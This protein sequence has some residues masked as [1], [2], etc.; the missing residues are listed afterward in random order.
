[1]TDPADVESARAHRRLLDRLL[2]DAVPAVGTFRQLLPLMAGAGPVD[3]LQGLVRLRAVEGI[4]TRA[5]QLIRDASATPSG[6]S[7]VDQPAALPLPHPLDSEWRFCADSVD[8]LVSKLLST[9]MPGD[10]L[11]LVGTPSLAVALSRSCADRRIRFVGPD[12]VVS[13][14]VADLFEGDGRLARKSSG[15]AAAA[16]VDP[17][18]YGAP[19]AEM[20]SVCAS[21]CRPGAPVLTVMPRLATRPDMAAGIEDM[22]RAAHGMGMVLTDAEP[23][24]VGYR[25]PVFEAAALE[26]HGINPTLG[27]W[28]RGDCVRF[29]AGGRP[30][31]GVVAEYQSSGGH[32]ELMLDGCRIRL[33]LDTGLSAAGL[34]AVEDD[35]IS[36]SVSARSP[37]RRAANLWTTANRALVVDERACLAA[38]TEIARYEGIVLPQRLTLDRI[39]PHPEK[40]VEAGVD[41]IHRLRALFE[42]ETADASRLAGDGS[43]LRGAKGMKCSHARSNTSLQSRPGAPA[44]KSSSTATRAA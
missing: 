10:E 1:M 8:A 29:D 2:W 28:R 12:D 18:W 11:L 32:V 9:T 39:E 33:M 37:S 42:R 16:V 41:M 22:L 26:R 38:I 44:L 5:E 15:R 35:E 4:G 36:G 7:V 34:A 14:A 31:S 6:G 3:V 20:L 25:T 43:W 30:E 24:E 13:A 17:P 27:D 19:F 21:G 23:I 40:I